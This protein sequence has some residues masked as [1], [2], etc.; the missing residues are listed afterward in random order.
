[1]QSY[2]HEDINNVIGKTISLKTSFIEFDFYSKIS[3]I[4]FFMQCENVD[5]SIV[6]MIYE[7]LTK[8]IEI[9]YYLNSPPRK[10]LKDIGI[11]DGD[12]DSIIDIIGEKFEKIADLQS[13]IKA[14]HHKLGNISIISKYVINNLISL[15]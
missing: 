6:S 10:M 15:F 12:I 8:N 7:K 13:L 9:L 4:K 1:M 11:Y 14:N 3:I 5:S 2:S